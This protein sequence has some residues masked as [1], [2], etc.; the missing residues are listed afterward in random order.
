MSKLLILLAFTCVSVCTLGL[1]Y[2]STTHW[3][4]RPVHLF[5]SSDAN[6]SRTDGL[7]LGWGDDEIV[8]L[9]RINNSDSSYERRLDIE[10]FTP[11]AYDKIVKTFNRTDEYISPQY[12]VAY[13]NNLRFTAKLNGSKLV[14]VKNMLNGTH[15]REFVFAD[16]IN[17]DFY[18][19]QILAHR[20]EYHVVLCNDTLVYIATFNEDFT[21]SKLSILT[22]RR[23]WI[24]PPRCVGIQGKNS[25]YCLFGFADPSYGNDLRIAEAVFDL[26]TRSIPQTSDF[27][28][29]KQVQFWING[30]SLFSNETTYGAVYF[31]TN[32]SYIKNAVTGRI[33]TFN[34]S[35]VK[36][37]AVVDSYAHDNQIAIF[38]ATPATPEGRGET[39]KYYNITAQY[40]NLGGATITTK[41]LFD[42]VTNAR[43]LNYEGDLF[44][45]GYNDTDAYLGQLWQSS[46]YWSRMTSSL[47]I[48]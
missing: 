41:N 23:Y 8:L 45:L 18:V 3:H 37:A 1:S 4:T 34:S 10:D 13:G 7:S 6:F 15:D 21:S 40:I 39:A 19:N 44:V 22:K 33:A 24:S 32:A 14:I 27:F 31:L 9:G 2:N 17:G 12:K 20:G 30:F 5:N 11:V 42:N 47:L 16:S 36:G 28:N 48:F 25:L 43:L 38:Y 26:S 29:N 46:S 35:L